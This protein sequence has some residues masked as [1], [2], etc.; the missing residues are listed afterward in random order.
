MMRAMAAH[1]TI[2]GAE[3]KDNVATLHHMTPLVMQEIVLIEPQSLSL[4]AQETIVEPSEYA[5]FIHAGR[6]IC[7]PVRLVHFE[8]AHHC[9]RA[10]RASG[11]SRGSNCFKQHAGPGWDRTAAVILIMPLLTVKARCNQ[12]WATEEPAAPEAPP[13]G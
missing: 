9:L 13:A 10:G 7:R 3:P 6:Q 11:G 12:R 2:P 5:L 8:Y 1:L 4:H